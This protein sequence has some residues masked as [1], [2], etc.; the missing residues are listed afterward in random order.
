[1]SKHIDIEEVKKR[2]EEAL[3]KPK[4]FDCKSI[5]ELL[6]EINI[7]YQELEVQNDELNRI[8]QDL[9]IS[10]K[11]FQDLYSN[12]PIPY[13]TY[14]ADANIISANKLFC[15][16]TGF[17]CDPKRKTSLTK[18]IHPD[19][20]NTF[21]FYMQNL[22]NSV[23][24][25]K[26]KQSDANDVDDIANTIIHVVGNN[27]VYKMKFESNIITQ[28]SKFSFR[29]AMFD[30][31]K[32]LESE[33]EIA[34]LYI[35]LIDKNKDL[36]TYKDRLDST[37]LA[38]NIAWWEMDLKSGNVKFNEQKA[39]MLGYEPERFTHYTHF[40]E[41]LHPE[42]YDKAMNAMLD[43][44][45]GK[46]QSYALDYRIKASN[47]SYKWFQDI[48]IATE[49]D[50]DGN[51]V[52]ISGVVF[53]ITQRKESEKLIFE[54]QQKFKSIFDQ[55]SV[56]I[57]YSDLDGKF[58]M[59]NKQ[60]CNIVGYSVDELIN[61]SWEIITFPADV[62][63]DKE[64]AGKLLNKEI[65]YYNIKKRYY[66]KQG[67]IVWVNLNVSLLY[68][69]H[70]GPVNFIGI[71]E[72]IS[73]DI[74]I[75]ETLRKSEEKFRLLY[76]TMGQ[77]VV[78]QDKDGRIISAN[79]A[80]CEILGISMDQMMG[81]TSFDP[82]WRAIK[83]DGTDFD[84]NLH[85]A[86][87]SLKTGKPVYNA[88][89]GVF[90]PVKNEYRWILISA[91][92]QFKNILCGFQTPLFGNMKKCK[93]TFRSNFKRS[94]ISFRIFKK[95]KKDKPYQVFTTFTDITI[96]KNAENKVRENEKVL[97]SIIDILPGTLN[98]V[99][100]DFNIITLNNTAF[101]HKLSGYNSVQ[102][103]IGKKCYEV[104]MKNSIPCSWCQIQKAIET[105]QA[106]EETTKPGD[107]REI[108]FGRAYKLFINPV[109]DDYG[110]IKGVVEYGM[111]ITEL[112][113]AILKAE[114]ATKAKSEFLANMSHELRTPLNGVI[115][116]TELLLSENI[117]KEHKEYIQNIYTS[118]HT[119]LNIIN[120][121]LDLSKIEAGK[122]ELEETTVDITEL[123]NEAIDIVKYQAS[124][125]NLELILNVPK[126]I[127]YYVIAD[128]LR[129][130]QIIINLLGNAVKFTKYGEV[131]LSLFADVISDNEVILS[132]AVRDTGIGISKENQK[133]LFKAFSQADASTTRSFGGTGLGLVISNKLAEK[134]NSEIILESTID[135][136]ST[137]SFSI[138]LKTIKK[139]SDFT[140][141]TNKMKSFI[142]IN[143]NLLL[144]ENN[145]NVQNY[146]KYLVEEIFTNIQSFKQLPD[147]KSL[148]NHKEI[149]LVII[150]YS[151][152]SKFCTDLR[153]HL[154]KLDNE[155]PVIV[156]YSS[157]E[158]KQVN[159]S[160]ISLS[161]VYKLAKP[162]KIKSLY[163]LFNDI[164]KCSKTIVNK[165]VN[166]I[167]QNISDNVYKI[168]IAEDNII[169]MMLIK[170]FLKKILPNA[171]IFEAQNGLQAVSEMKSNKPDIVFMDI[172]MPDLDGFDATMQIRHDSSC[173][174]IAII[175]L[176]AGVSEKE[177]QKCLDVGMSE[178]MSK[179]VD[180][181]I[182][183]K[184]LKKYLRIE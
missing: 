94:M 163:Y 66:H 35:E 123:L 171:I 169:N 76:K 50:N 74:L 125:K 49:R 175:A 158:E 143:R 20:Q 106:I 73:N 78:Y 168:L 111:D 124:V 135:Q 113:D 149:S 147:V 117:N 162:V 89:M 164:C 160:I 87:V 120:D 121:I 34:K 180:K 79:K 101:R 31:T 134:M 93:P 64:L 1:M 58:I 41:L 30:L 7:N 132:F 54:N 24:T 161:N 145:E 63:S 25:I 91:V 92:P 141:I 70:G 48:G 27:Q 2:I 174:N 98:Y 4:K 100:K 11:H 28:N 119:L 13:V 103:V 21:Y 144:I 181:T 3:N 29:T 10:Q 80:A 75:K 95:L 131:E 182:L 17:V 114:T 16:I 5:D 37:M 40:T 36:Q 32:E 15:K 14:D 102:D 53:D 137:F 51:I 84:G 62:K 127:S 22:S 60:F 65:S 82:K 151:E 67:H 138:K 88:T 150:E 112:R 61:N 68:D 104:F 154:G 44:I 118:A 183:I 176:T 19:Y 130:K 126:N 139:E 165:E 9:E 23:K 47:G 38:G 122:L 178:I 153:K 105:R 157:V 90:H 179:P 71:I 69:N 159:D 108:A 116:F 136:G 52:L 107:P 18:F 110:N 85:P 97:Q 86:M 39:R 167:N 46:K 184:Y 133:K 55:S 12:A 45:S 8:R 6:E 59:A 33:E 128:P 96:Q 148:V 83:E 173:S 72:D 56:G 156:L 140:E 109:I 172:Q 152:L 26:A 99:D 115:G 43:Y 146:I 170:T 155:L 57:C 129:L 77:G 42:D 81:K 177:K 142:S 166:V